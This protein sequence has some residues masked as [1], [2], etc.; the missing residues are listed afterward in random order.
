MKSTIEAQKHK[1]Q[2]NVKFDQEDI[3]PKAKKQQLNIFWGSDDEG[4]EDVMPR[5][6]KDKSESFIDIHTPV[7]EYDDSNFSNADKASLYR[8]KL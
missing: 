5:M 1:E 7:G 6:E 8:F 2:T 3:N 4:T